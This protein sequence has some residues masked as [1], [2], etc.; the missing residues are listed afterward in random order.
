M[1]DLNVM[2]TVTRLVDL[3]TPLS[4]DERRRVIGASLALLGEEVTSFQKASGP[5]NYVS[6]EL[7]SNFSPRAQSWMVQY[8]ITPTEIQQVFHSTEEHVEVIALEIPGKSGG[9]KT[10]AVYVLTGIASLLA[11]GDAAFDDDSAR[12]LC[13]TLGCF[14]LANHSAYL[15]ERGNE[16]VGSKE[17][18]WTLTAPGLKRGAALVKELNKAK[19]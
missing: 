7:S 2:E 3:L 8:S 13:R 4:S 17:K 15:K 16:L 10:R 1:P 9:E 5:P 11:K 14:N 19:E 12:N 6:E 18:G